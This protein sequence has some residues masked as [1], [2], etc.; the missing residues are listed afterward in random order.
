MGFCKQMKNNMNK[1][2]IRKIFLG[3]VVFILLFFSIVSIRSV[4]FAAGQCGADAAQIKEVQGIVGVTQDGICGPNTIA[5]IKQYQQDNGLTPDGIVGPATLSMMGISTTPNPNPNPPPP[6]P[7]PNPLPPSGNAFCGTGYS[8]QNGLCIPD[9]PFKTGLASKGT[10]SDLISE[11]LKILLT[12]AGI[13]AVILIIIGGFQYMTAGGN[14]EQA[15][16]GRKALTNAVIGLVIVMLSYVI[17]A[18]ISNTL[19]TTNVIK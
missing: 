16:K 18:V 9:S 12:L 13:V 6:N 5:A 14:E 3:M 17:V 19:T 1:L 2:K 4:A 8:M 10:L 11:V 15:E 7:N